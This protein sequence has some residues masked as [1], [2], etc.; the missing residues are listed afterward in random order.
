MTADHHDEHPGTHPE[1]ELSDRGKR[2]L[3]IH[4]LLIEKGVV[5]RDEVR[6]GRPEGEGAYTVG[7]CAGCREGVVGQ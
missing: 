7:R 1:I 2:A 6:E 3:A 4:E 5:G